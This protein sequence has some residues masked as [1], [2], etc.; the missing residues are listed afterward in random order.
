MDVLVKAIR[1]ALLVNPG[2]T[3]L[4]GSRIYNKQAPETAAY[5]FIVIIANGGGE[6][7]DS[8][9]DYIDA[10]YTVKAIAT[11]G[12]GIINA[13]GLAGQVS[14]AIRKALHKQTFSMDAPWTLVR[15]Q[16]DSIVDYIENVDRKQFYHSGGLF[17]IRAYGG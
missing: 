14:D 12:E 2:V 7:N 17:R 13:G 4:V 15:C 5:P 11:N 1:D 9:N 10:D 6:T 16:R 8:D 3:N